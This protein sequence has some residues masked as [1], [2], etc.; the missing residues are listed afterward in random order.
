MNPLRRFCFALALLLCT[1]TPALADPVLWMAKSPTA[2]IYLFGTVHV[3]PDATQW[4]YPALDKALAASGT[5]YVEEDDDDPVTMQLL[6]LQYGMDLQHPLSGKLDAAD[7]AQLDAAAKAAGV[8]GGSTTLDAMRPWLAALTIAVAPIVKAGYDPKSGADKQLERAFR[9]S[10][11]P[12]GAF[13]TA[14]QQ[15]KFFADLSPA[16]Q[17]DLLRNALDDYAEGPAQIGKLIGYWQSGNVAAIAE[18]VNGGMREHYPDLYKV[19]LV[20]RNQAWARQIG[21]LLE[22]RGTIFVA[23]GAGHLAGPD[24]VLVQLRKLGIAT[25]RVH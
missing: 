25:E 6:V 16:L 24:S 9:T 15:I 12:I 2:T 22:G 17:L 14:E 3:L 13:E 5:L 23:V 19:L 18:N 20:E 7:R 21:T 11:K 4:R 8:A 10:G 1:S